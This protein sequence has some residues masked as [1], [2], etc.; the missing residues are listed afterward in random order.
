[1]RDLSHVHNFTITSLGYIKIRQETP[2]LIKIAL[3]VLSGIQTL[4]LC[5]FFGGFS[6]FSSRGTFDIKI[7]ISLKFDT[8][9]P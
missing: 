7:L 6:F 9:K 1:M 2:I 5:R 3:N 4:I 8:A